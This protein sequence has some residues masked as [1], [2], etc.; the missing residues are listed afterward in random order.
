VLAGRLTTEVQPRWELPGAR[1]GVAAE[2]GGGV[3]AFIK[4][5]RK[6]ASFP[7]LT[8]SDEFNVEESKGVGIRVSIRR[9]NWT[10]GLK[11]K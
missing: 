4:G 8:G 11:Q 9:N 7:K 6:S 3:A 5:D 10:L 2:R 1:G